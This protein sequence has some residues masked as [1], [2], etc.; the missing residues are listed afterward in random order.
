MGFKRFSLLIIARTVALMVSLALLI[1]AWLQPGY[2]AAT[3][4]MFMVIIGQFLELVS[5]VTK[6]NGELVRFLD[7]ARYADFSQRFELTDMGS[8]FEELGKAFSEILER[9]QK[10]RTEN[11]Q[12]LRHI[13]AL[14]EHVPVPLVSLKAEQQLQLWNNSARRLFG[15]NPVVNLSDL[16]VFGAHF[17]KQLAAMSA[18]DKRLIQISI[19]GIDHKLS[20]AATQVTIG[21]QSEL[22]L[23]LQDIH[24]ELAFAQLQA[25]QDLVR[26]LTHEIMNSITP[27]SSLAKTAVDL[28]D[29]IAKQSSLPLELDE[30]LQ[31]VS[32][33]VKTVARRSDGLMQFVSSYRQ[34][35]RLP[36]PVRRDI[37]LSTFFEQLIPIFNQGWSD[38]EIQFSCEVTP[39]SLDL[40]VDKDMLEQVIIN[41]MKNA[42]H[43]IKQGQD[44][45]GK[46]SLSAYINKRGRTVI[47]VRDNGVGMSQDVV[48]NA[49]V[50]FYTTKRDG[51]GVGL[52]LTRQVMLAHGGHV[53]LE[54]EEGEGARFQ[55]IF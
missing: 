23:S 13:K 47:E 50:P 4:V 19:D 35:T 29:D 46:I 37:A 20:V 7:A 9:L 27:V 26:V 34:L 32:D 22:L 42:E 30:E 6:T 51:S 17:P 36:E 18:G 54:S 10:V 24:N 49:F 48:D 25:W 16:S 14:M 31:D 55:L 38:K 5:F 15:A 8:G 11:E 43:A 39:T 41:L 40:S 3:I 1:L 33:A 2:H 28:V 45:Q 44:K 53:V 21:S 12:E 52:A